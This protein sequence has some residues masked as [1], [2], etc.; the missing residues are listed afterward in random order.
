M[1]QYGAALQL[2][3]AILREWHGLK[4]IFANEHRS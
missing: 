1:P 3:L 2:K 4:N